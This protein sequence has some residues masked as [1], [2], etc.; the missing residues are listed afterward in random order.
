MQNLIYAASFPI[1]PETEV[2][3][4]NA[5]DDGL[6][7]YLKQISAGKQKSEWACFYCNAREGSMFPIIF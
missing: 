6:N 7:A 3:Q 4:I 1:L 2:Y 5:N